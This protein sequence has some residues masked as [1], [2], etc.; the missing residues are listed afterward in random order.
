MTCH[1]YLKQVYRS[2]LMKFHILKRLIGS[3]A[4]ATSLGLM[5]AESAR[6]GVANLPAIAYFCYMIDQQGVLIDLELVCDPNARLRAAAEAAR[7]A[8][9][10]ERRKLA[11]ERGEPVYCRF[12]TEMASRI[13][14][15][16][17]D[18][19]ISVP[20]T[21][22]VFRDS[23]GF[24]LWMQLK[25]NGSRILGEARETYSLV[26]AGD[27]FIFDAEFEG[28]FALNPAKQD[29]SVIYWVK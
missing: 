24:Q 3:L 4:I 21:C 16:E 15:S 13:E 18:Y 10:A 9:E 5:A 8:E 25:L 28:E 2:A 27:S 17:G 12:F 14:N 7:A 22:E 26:Q 11:L 20:T 6:A 19:V 29:L 1:E 23:S